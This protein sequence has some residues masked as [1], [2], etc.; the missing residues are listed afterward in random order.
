VE[1]EKRGM[2][3]EAKDEADEAPQNFSFCHIYRIHDYRIRSMIHV[4]NVKERERVYITTQGERERERGEEGRE[5]TLRLA[6]KDLMVVTEQLETLLDVARQI[7]DG[8][9]QVNGAAFGFD[10]GEKIFELVGKNI[11]L[12][13]HLVGI[14]DEVHGR[15][16]P[17]M[18]RVDPDGD[19][20]GGV[21]SKHAA[22]AT[23]GAAVTTAGGR[24]R[25]GCG[26]R[27]RRLIRGASGGAGRTAD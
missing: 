15:L 17:Q 8:A 24:G 6:D 1:G 2:V 25:A 7:H 13:P 23:A 9:T 22:A 10:E 5:I 14:E 4:R 20:D 16:I 11:R 12:F 21:G 26:G 3:A 18:I 27:G 19:G